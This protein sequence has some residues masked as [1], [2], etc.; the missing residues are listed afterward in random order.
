M[1]TTC[2]PL[3]G[4]LSCHCKDVFIQCEP[5][6]EGC[7]NG[8]R[9]LLKMSQRCRFLWNDANLLSSLTGGPPPTSHP[10]PAG[11]SRT[12]ELPPLSRAP[13]SSGPSSS[14][15][16][17]RSAGVSLMLNPTEP[18]DPHNDRPRKI[19]RTES[20][21]SIP[22]LPPLVTSNQFYH[23]MQDVSTPTG[24]H[25]AKPPRRLLTPRLSARSPTSLHRAVSLSQLPPSVRQPQRTSYPTSPRTASYGIDMTSAGGS[26]LPTPPVAAREAYGFPAPAT[27]NT[28]RRA[29][30]GAIHSARLQSESTS[31]KSTYSGYSQAEQASPVQYGSSLMPTLSASYTG[32]SSNNSGP[33]TD[34]TS[35][36]RRSERQS[37]M[38]IPISSANGQ[39]V[40]QMMTLETSSGTVQLPVDVQAASRVADEKRRRN[41]G[42][43]ARFRQR[44]KEKEREASTAISRLEQR[45]K[46]LGEDAEFYKRERDYFLGVVLQV[47]G[48]D[49]HFPRPQSPRHRRT[50]S[51]G[52]SGGGHYMSA[53]ERGSRSP[54]EGRSGRRRTSTASVN[55]P[56][57]AQ[58]HG[59]APVPRSYVPQPYGQQPL[60]QAP[61]PLPSPG[62][63]GMPLSS[64]MH[65][66]PQPGVW[67]PYSNQR[68]TSGDH[69]YRTQ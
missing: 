4:Q 20:T 34:D 47:P 12:M 43:S 50:S 64:L 45:L 42:A 1:I 28:S 61:G 32:T 60:Q 52:G 51:V 62:P 6:L 10:P 39:N 54:G 31:P 17:S 14:T 25:E 15:S 7:A 59:P 66:A 8:E 49:R 65:P 13:T 22:P 53:H 67:N 16:A 24:V 35:T 37:H 30:L 18:E 46:D 38:G 33:A 58:S 19:A 63:G 26:V 2:F 27:H 3:H 40:Y 68:Q 11:L 69:G 41:A 21:R 56:P 9:C 55:P 44:R 57:H 36:P 48:G 29:S 5:T 23:P